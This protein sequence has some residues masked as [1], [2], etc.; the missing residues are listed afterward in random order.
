M[1]KKILINLRNLGEKL[2]EILKYFN[3]DISEKGKLRSQNKNA[4]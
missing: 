4:K 2:D 3:E 1:L